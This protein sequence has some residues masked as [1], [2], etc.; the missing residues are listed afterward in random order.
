MM[1]SGDASTSTASRYT[2]LQ[3]SGLWKMVQEF[4]S[5]MDH[6]V[7]KDS[8]IIHSNHSPT[9]RRS[10][11]ILRDR[12]HGTAKGFPWTMLDGQL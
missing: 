12:G 6:W 1:T 4:R 9:G 3:M 8:L 11:T 7:K 5:C 2:I 10:Q